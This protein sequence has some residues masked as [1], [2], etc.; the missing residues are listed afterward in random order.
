[1]FVSNFWPQIGGAENQA[2]LLATELVKNCNEVV[3]LTLNKDNLESVEQLNGFKVVRISVNHISHRFQHIP[4]KGLYNL[5][6]IFLSLC[7]NSK[8]Y[9]KNADV[10]HC[11]I[12]NLE[13]FLVAFIARLHSKPV[14]CKAATGSFQS[15]IGVMKKSGII[16][17]IFAL[18]ANK[19]FNKW[20]ATNNSVKKQLLN[21]KINAGKISLIPNSVVQQQKVEKKFEIKKFLYLGRLAKTANRDIPTM[22]RAFDKISKN[23]SDIELS[24]VG[25]GDMYNE[26]KDHVQSINNGSIRMIGFDDSVK[27][28]RWADCIIQPSRFEGFS[29]TLIEAMSHNVICIANDIPSNRELLQNGALGFLTKVGCQD[30]LSNNIEKVINTQ[31][32]ND[33]ANKAFD[34][35]TNNYSI[36]MNT[37]K[38]TALYK[39]LINNIS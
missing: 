15:D 33:I 14:I 6:S 24:I 21:A 13:S 11:H 37:K 23:Y 8:K 25:D 22:L 9:V 29:G 10:V 16:N 20:I 3:V 32:L 26:T 17:R 12:G 1:M 34:Y 35:V 36:K 38:Y 39:S 7:F 5:I 2:K 31:N 18:L 27:W 28:L 4:G 30:D 19:I